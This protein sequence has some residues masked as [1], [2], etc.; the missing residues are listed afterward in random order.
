MYMQFLNGRKLRSC[1]H[2]ITHYTDFG[3]WEMDPQQRLTDLE[4]ILNLETTG[5]SGRLERSYRP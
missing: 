2:D 3:P 4:I 1:L 5:L